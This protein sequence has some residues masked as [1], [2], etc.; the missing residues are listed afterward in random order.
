[1]CVL[2]DLFSFSQIFRLVTSEE[3]THPEEYKLLE[4]NIPQQENIK[5]CGVFV[6]GY[7]R[8]W[9]FFDTDKIC[10][11]DIN[12]YRDLILYELYSSEIHLFDI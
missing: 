1:M 7:M 8:R 12:T 11:K 2:S 6:I 4:E 9:S 10:Q 5:D 3:S